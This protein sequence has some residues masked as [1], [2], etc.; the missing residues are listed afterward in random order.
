MNIA[1]A[2]QVLSDIN[3]SIG[4]IESECERVCL[5]INEVIENKYWAVRYKSEKEWAV[6]TFSSFHAFRHLYYLAQSYKDDLSI[7]STVGRKKAEQLVPVKNAE[8]VISQEWIDKARKY[9]CDHLEHFIRSKYPS[10]QLPKTEIKEIE[11][12]IEKLKSELGFHE[13]MILKIKEKLPVWESRLSELKSK[14]S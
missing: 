4:M 12:K 13:R 11:R 2:N 8:G 10:R 14:V 9:N 6:S 1:R 5:L 7:I 3:N